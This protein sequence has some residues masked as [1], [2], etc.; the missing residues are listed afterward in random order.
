MKAPWGIS[1]K[2]DGQRSGWGEQFGNVRKCWYYPKN[3]HSKNLLVS[4]KTRG[5]GDAIEKRY[6]NVQCTRGDGDERAGAKK[7]NA[8][9]DIRRKDTYVNHNFVS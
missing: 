1:V 6:S 3:F 7:E 2:I 5:S 4:G 9:K 8:K